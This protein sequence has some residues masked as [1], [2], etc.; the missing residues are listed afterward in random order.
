MLAKYRKCE[1]WLRL[2]AFFGHIISNEGVEVDPRK[3]EAVKNWPRPL[4]PT[5]FMSFLGLVGYYQRFVV[6]FTS[7]A[8]SLTTST[9]KTN[10]IEWSESCKR[11]FQIFKDRL[12]STPILTLLEGTK[13]FIVYYDASQ[14]GLGCVFMQHG[15]VKDYSS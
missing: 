15:K 4:T 13:V 3:T 8:S 2:V 1:F 14:M 7:I 10:K 12:T 5:N 6:G 9:Q 11:S